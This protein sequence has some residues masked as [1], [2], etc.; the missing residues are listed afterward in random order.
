MLA[1]QPIQLRKSAPSW[2]AFPVRAFVMLLPA[3]LLL[4]GVQRA[5]DSA[6]DILAVGAIVQAVLGGL[7]LL[8]RRAWQIP[9]SVLV[10]VV[11]LA[12]LGW[13]WFGAGPVRDWYPHLAQGIL[14]VVPL[15]AFAL[16]T[17][18]NSGAPALRRANLLAG[19]L[20]SR[21]EWPTDLATCRELPEV[22]AFREALH[23][24]AT[25][26]LNLLQ[27]PRNEIRMA[28]L[29]ALE[30]RKHWR[31]GQ[32]ELVLQ[33]ARRSPEPTLR[34]AAIGALANVEDRLLIE[35]LAEFL[36]D[37][38]DEVRR[39]AAEA[40]L[41]DCQRRWSWVRLAVRQALAN[42]A[43]VSDGPLLFN[44]QI[45]PPEAIA[46]FQA[47]AA[48]KSILG[49]RA[50]CT[51][52]SYYS[53]LLS[54][55]PDPVL[56]DDVKRQLA[57]VQAP[58]VLRMELAQLLRR[59]GMWDLELQEQL[60]DPANPASL[61][62]MAAESL[63]SDSDYPRAVE[64]LHDIAR[65]ANREIAL[66]TAEVVQRCLGIDLGLPLGQPLPPLHSRQAAEVTRRV[67]LWGCSQ[68]EHRL[69][70]GEL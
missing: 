49:A 21:R 18:V 5:P 17:L 54:E 34:C 61:R 67:M 52:G 16:Q 36:Q 66:A 41:W 9:A 1:G 51:L 26:A 20:T 70:S 58:P 38:A 46:D 12:G 37:P 44:G 63:L 53:Y 59:C 56:I 32:A 25:P 22:K 2:L 65:L 48:E 64:A 15:A 69:V 10:I 7:A 33:L 68:L 27:D 57:D 13:L 42:P 60:L 30:F 24:D 40:I 14:L 31:R 23:P 29:A 6:R 45:L 39:A 19:R 8:R 3:G 11:Y 35:A 28:A 4:L 50:A 43:Y 62:L 47:W 55:Q